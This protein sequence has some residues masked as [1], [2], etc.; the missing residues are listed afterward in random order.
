MERDE[1]RAELGAFLRR[2]R[3]EV[4][5]ADRGLPGA[6]P[7]GRRPLGLRREEVCYLAGMSVS[8]YSWL[9][10]GRDINPSRQVLDAVSRALELDDAEHD[11]V[12]SLAGHASSAGDTPDPEQPPPGHVHRLLD[13]LEAPAF[14][15]TRFWR[16]RAWNAA[17]ARLF[18]PIAEVPVA[19]RNL[20]WLLFTDPAVRDLLPDWDV[21][22]RRFLAEFR[23]EVA[24]RLGDP[25]LDALV[26][27]LTA[28]SE[29]FRAWWPDRDVHGFVS[30]RRRFRHP[31]RGVLTLEHHLVTLA[32]PPDLRLVIYLPTADGP[33]A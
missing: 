8:W 18:P 16:I 29:E 28:A 25:E 10:Q 11:Y 14:A 12:L 24:P 33:G 6:G 15:L 20:L 13:A 5:R 21:D 3:G 26:A 23:A 17:Y 31:E 7:G 22:V 32:D 1:R 9:E 2:R 4:V 30:R 27:R 19:E